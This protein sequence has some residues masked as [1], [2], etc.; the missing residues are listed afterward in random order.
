MGQVVQC[1]LS[2]L[3]LFFLSL[4]IQSRKLTPKGLIPHLSFYH[5]CNLRQIKIE[6]INI[7]IVISRHVTLMSSFQLTAV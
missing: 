2:R 6:N 5:L 3:E 4:G 1:W 7:A